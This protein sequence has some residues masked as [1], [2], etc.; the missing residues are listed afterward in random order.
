[1]DGVTSPYSAQLKLLRKELERAWQERTEAWAEFE[2]I[3]RDVP[4]IQPALVRLSEAID[5]HIRVVNRYVDLVTQCS[6]KFGGD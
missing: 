4:S 3:I 2:A 6:M 5:A 1:M